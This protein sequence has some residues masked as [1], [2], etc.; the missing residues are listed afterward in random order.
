MGTIDPE[1]SA[2]F[3]EIRGKVGIEEQAV[4]YEAPSVVS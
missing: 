4:A 3:A 2:F 1:Y